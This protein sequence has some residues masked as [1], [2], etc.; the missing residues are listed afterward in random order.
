MMQNTRVKRT[1]RG[2][3][4][5]WVLG[6]GLMA[7]LVGLVFRIPLSRM[8]GDKGVGFFAAAMEIFAVSSAVMCYGISKAVAILVKY[9]AKRDMYKSAKKIYQSAML[10][11]ILFSTL[12]AL[13]VFFFSEFIA[14]TFVLEYR[15]YL[16]VAAIAPA[17]LLSGLLGIMRGYLQGMGA[18]MPTVHSRLL[19][20]FVMLVV[21]LLLAAALFSYG[22]K[23][24]ALLRDTEYAAAY[25]AMGASIGVSVACGIGILHMVLIRLIYAGTFKQQLMGD[26]AKYV[27]S[28]GQV[29]STFFSAALPYM[30]CALLYNIHYLVDQRV[31]N[32]AMNK[33]EKGSIRVA[34]WGVY[35][36]KYSVVIGIVAIICTLSAISAIP[37]IAQ[38]YDKQE[39]GEV[40]YRIGSAIHNLAVLTIPCAV[41]VAVLAKPIVSMLFKGDQDTA[42]KLLQSGSGVIVLF[43]FGYFLMLLMQRIHKFKMVILGGL[44]AF[45]IHLIF[46]FILISSTELGII[47]VVLGLLVFWLVVCVTGFIGIVQ[48]MQYSPEWIRTFG[49][50]AAA[51]GVSGI[52]GMLLGKVMISW[53]GGIATF[54]VC[55]IVCILIY[56]VLMI[57]LRGIREDELEDMPGG[58]IIIVLAERMRL[59]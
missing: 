7:W 36:G 21:G 53:A 42:V 41:W 10:F 27:E 32:Y 22:E 11:T 18:M 5:E 34:H 31:F 24:A 51:S 45:L 12:I 52:V 16:A 33:Q 57:A 46:L 44:A 6:V 35:Y 56:L 15:S 59:L 4:R 14:Q 55:I 40:K 48:Y 58:R 19:E 54:F 28:N 43:T 8:I 39:Y 38:M 9:R 50:T 13:F 23:V 2:K 26:T 49:V 3:R 37:K 29:I 47:A 1:G 17:I 20:K 30:I 25:G